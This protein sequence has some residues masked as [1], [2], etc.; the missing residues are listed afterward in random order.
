MEFRVGSNKY[1]SGGQVLKIEKVVVNEHFKLGS[2]DNDIALVKVKPMKLGRKV[3]PIALGTQDLKGGTK[4][5]VSGWGEKNEVNFNY[6]CVQT[7]LVSINRKF[8]F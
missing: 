8:Y 3:K 7:L 6:S 4:V 1:S 2:W 5:V